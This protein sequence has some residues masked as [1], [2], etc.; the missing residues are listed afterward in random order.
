MQEQDAVID[1]FDDQGKNIGHK[2]RYEINKRLD[3]L[4]QVN[5]V[6]ID[7][8]KRMFVTKAKGGLWPGKWGTS[9]AGLVRHDEALADAAKRT[10]KR[11][12]GI[13]AELKWFGESMYNFDGIKRLFSVFSGSTKAEPKLNPEDAE[14]GKWV[15][16]EEAEQMIK[17]DECMPTFAIALEVIKAK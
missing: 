6:V 15:T 5:M 3:I 4:K 10:L 7:D 16:F 1:I 9:A 12:L 17:N 13:S 8:K 11:E 14:E 2:F